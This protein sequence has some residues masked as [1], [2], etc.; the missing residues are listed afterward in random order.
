MQPFQNKA[1][2]HFKDS[3]RAKSL[4]QAKRHNGRTLRFETFEPRHLMAA[5][6]GGDPSAVLPNDSTDFS[7]PTGSGN[8][9]AQINLAQVNS[10][11]SVVVGAGEPS[12]TS[13]IRYVSP[14]G[15]AGAGTQADPWSLDYAN[16]AVQAGETILMLDGTY[17]GI[18]KPKV[19][20]TFGNPIT[21]KPAP[22]ANVHLRAI[23]SEYAVNIG[24]DYIL[25]EGLQ[26]SR[27]DGREGDSSGVT[28]VIIF[29]DHVTVRNLHVFNNGDHIEQARLYSEVGIVPRGEYGLVENN[30]IENMK[31]GMSLGTDRRG[32]FYNV[33]RGNTI[34]DSVYDGIHIGRGLGAPLH[35]L[36]ENNVIFGAMVSD[37]ITFDGRNS[38]DP[39][40]HLGI[41]Q[42]I[43]RNNAIFNSGENN[44]DLKATTN[45]I[46]EGNFLW[47]NFG[48]NDGSNV[49][50]IHNGPGQSN[51]SLI[52][53]ES[54]GSGITKGSGTSSEHVIIRNNVM[55]D[56]NQAMPKLNE[57]KIYNNTLL[58]NRRNYNGPNQ[59]G[60]LPS[61][62]KPGDVAIKGNGAGPNF[63]IF[64]NIIGDH[65]HEIAMQPGGSGAIDGN[66][67]YNTFQN[68]QFSAFA[69]NNDWTTESFVAWQAWLQ[70][71]SNLSGNDTNSQ[72]VSGGPSSLFV[73]V[74]SQPTGDPAQFDFHLT[75]NSPAI[76]GGVF[77]TKTVGSG[78]GTSMTVGDAKLFFD[79]Y[80][81]TLG[82]EIQL[83]GQTVRARI[84][85]ISGNTL[86]L[87]QSLTWGN[88]VGLSMAYQGNTPDVGAIEYSGAIPI[89]ANP[90]SVTTSFETAVI[91]PNVLANDTFPM[92]GTLSVQS[93]SQPN[94]GSVVA[95]GD[96][97]F[98]YV[99][100]NGFEGTDTFTYT[101]IDG[102]GG[103]DIGTVSITVNADVPAGLVGYWSLDSSDIDGITVLDGSG[104]YHDGTMQFS[105][106]PIAGEIG[107]GLDFQ[108][109]DYV[110]I[111]DDDLFDVSQI[112]IAAWINVDN[113]TR[114][115]L[116]SK[117]QGSS[118]D[119]ETES[120][121]RLRF[122]ADFGAGIVS[123][124]S[125]HGIY[126]AG[127]WLHVT[128]T[129]DGSHVAFYVNGVLE[130]TN[131][132]T[133]QI[134]SDEQDIKIGNSQLHGG[135]DEVRIYDHALTQ[136]EIA[137]LADPGLPADFDA[138]G[139]VDGAD[140]LDW[141]RGFSS[142]YVAADLTD[143]EDNFGAS[144]SSA[145]ASMA[146]APLAV[147]APNPVE[148]DVLSNEVGVVLALD[149]QPSTTSSTALD[150]VEDN[151]FDEGG[152]SAID[153]ALAQPAEDK[154]PIRISLDIERDPVETKEASDESLDVLF[155]LLGNSVG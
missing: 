60:S 26:V 121:G 100:N 97:T 72:T 139:D 38:S 39:A 140:F 82:D 37:G 112:T 96:N 43:I 155:E 62:R 141:Q 55:I 32:S 124:K 148:A 21:Y 20:G 1:L 83:E 59:P 98:T 36:I 27:R 151:Q 30:L 66:A 44:I 68:P 133:G 99:P 52:N 106:T 24:Q 145:A 111:D 64:N 9:A 92:G 22:G 118:Y 95:N 10:V 130:G 74:P 103:T 46:V 123:H 57:Y 34:A 94:R 114:Q 90:D 137:A 134:Q 50:D 19:S 5:D 6:L 8:Y 142:T 16:F 80:G 105:P 119:L 35:H 13:S 104:H 3:Q 49:L 87:D 108:G 120:G 84:T 135:I 153:A 88:G 76:D 128:V 115:D 45:I 122:N 41:N 86:T 126:T 29:S 28:N 127:E 149:L 102:L 70:T 93:F 69:D 131:A 152:A 91:T 129:Y 71:R 136:P 147:V 63:A 143:W 23:G 146:T 2:R 65:W 75:A 42:V 15:G 89:S 40:D 58:N 107:G 77:L 11:T 78:S 14:T 117:N 85:S 132:Q 47:K 25:V 51:T 56:N 144:V 73:D 17:D 125:P 116:V 113:N 109:G 54:G 53:D 67:Y 101:L 110:T 12:A 33:L 31:F 81:I 138:D 48:D 154:G 79:G 61:D 18:I 7:Y 4:R 150:V